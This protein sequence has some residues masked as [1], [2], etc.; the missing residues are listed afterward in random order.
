[1]PGR[2]AKGKLTA[3][4]VKTAQAPERARKA[5]KELAKSVKLPGAITRGERRP[6]RRQVDASCRVHA[7]REQSGLSEARFAR[8]PNLGARMSRSREQA[9]R[10]P[11]GPAKAL[12]RIFEKEPAPRERSRP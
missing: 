10:E 3:G 7:V 5:L 8:L 4:E 11:T 2:A 12:L 1:M 6:S 9:R